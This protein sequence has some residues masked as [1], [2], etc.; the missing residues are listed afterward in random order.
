MLST[1]KNF[2]QN[3]FDEGVCCDNPELA[4]LPF[5]NIFQDCRPQW[6]TPRYAEKDALSCVFI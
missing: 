2:N 5:A 3:S 4:K 6:S 1:Q